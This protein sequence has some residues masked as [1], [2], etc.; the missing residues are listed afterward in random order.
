VQAKETWLNI[1]QKIRYLRKQ[2]QLT[3]KQLANGCG[4]SR[5]AVSLLERGEV[6]P[7]VAT[8]CKI[9]T[10]LGVPAGSLFQ[11]ICPNEVVLTRAQDRSPGRLSE[12]T[13]K[14]LACSVTS[15]SSPPTSELSDLVED[16][17]MLPPDYS[18]EFVLCLSGH[19]EYEADGR[20]YQLEPG[21]S[22]T[23]NGNVF[24]C[25]RNLSSGTAVA[26]M[27]LYAKPPSDV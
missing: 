25:W 22:L 12:Q 7:T 6:A 20:S 16:T 14:A 15:Q 3:I 4:L 11:D 24:H 23:C 2:H 27:I 9:A 21:D 10:A 19:I 13:L 1:G 18:D 8:L 17:E 5:N 26:V